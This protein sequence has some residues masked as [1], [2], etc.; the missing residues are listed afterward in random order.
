MTSDRLRRAAQI[1]LLADRGR[2]KPYGVEFEQRPTTTKRQLGPRRF[3]VCT[4]SFCHRR[5]AS[6]PAYL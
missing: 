4:V 6:L 5:V 3:A 2:G 1:V